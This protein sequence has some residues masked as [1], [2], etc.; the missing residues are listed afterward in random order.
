MAYTEW[1]DRLV[2]HFFG[3]HC[4]GQ[5]VRLM[6]TRRFLDE[7]MPDLGGTEGFLA[8]V[9]EGPEWF[10]AAGMPGRPRSLHETALA[11]YH[12]HL[13]THRPHDYPSV[14]YDAP[15][16]LAYLCLLCLAW[17]EGSEDVSAN[18]FYH[19]LD[20][21][22][23]EHDLT[24]QRLPQWRALW[25]GL[26]NWTV[27]SGGHLGVFTF[28]VLGHM[29]HVGTPRSQVLLNHENVDRLPR[30]FSHCGLQPA[31]GTTCEDLRQILYAHQIT[32]RQVL[33]H[34]LA[35]EIFEGGPLGRAAL[36]VVL[37]YLAEWDGVL[38]YLAEE[39]QN[40]DGG[41]P[42]HQQA[43]RNSYVLSV[44]L[45]CL[46]NGNGWLTTV[47]VLDQDD[48]SQMRVDEPPWRFASVTSQLL[49]ATTVGNGFVNVGVLG[50]ELAG[51]LDLVGSWHDDVGGRRQARLSLRDRRLRVFGWHN[52]RWLVEVDGLADE[53]CA[54][55][56]CASAMQPAWEACVQGCEPG[57]ILENELPQAG[58]PHGWR[59]ACIPDLAAVAAASRQE[60]RQLI[61]D[62]AQTP[63]IRLVGGSRVYAGVTRRTYLPYDP[64]KIVVSLPGQLQW[65]VQGAS[66]TEM[67][68]AAGG[69]GPVDGSPTY[70]TIDVDDDAHHVWARCMRDGQQVA[71]PV[72]I[73]ILRDAH[74]VASGGGTEFF[75]DR[76]GNR[77]TEGGLCGASLSEPPDGW[78]FDGED[79]VP[80]ARPA[81]EEPWQA[82]C[83]SFLESLHMA[84]RRL[85]F[86][87]VRR[88]AIDIAGVEAALVGREMRWLCG[89]GFVEIERDSRGRWA[90]VYPVP[91]CLY[92]LP[93]RRHGKYQ[94]VLSGC[95]RVADW[96]NAAQ[97]A[98]TLECQ[99][100]FHV[101]HTSLI[102]PRVSFF[103]DDVGHLQ[104][105]ANQSGARWLQFPP[106][107]AIAHWSA[108]LEEW[109]EELRWFEGEGPSPEREYAAPLFRTVNGNN[110]GIADCRLYCMED[111]QTHQHQ[112][113]TL[114]RQDGEAT[115]HTFVRDPAWGRWTVHTSAMRELMHLAHMEEEAVR[116]PYE[117]HTGS[118][119]LP[120]EL[121]LPD[122]LNRSL[123]LCSGLVPRVVRG[124]C[125]AYTFSGL[126]FTPGPEYRGLCWVY[127]QIP[128]RVAETV[129]SK[130]HARPVDVQPDV[131][132]AC[133][134]QA[135]R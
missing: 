5:P 122:V 22:Y 91:L 58:L 129:L 42:Q 93:L 21:L 50:D 121:T 59:L 72:S 75:L 95:A 1:L 31:E 126:H 57:Q 86:A 73:N 112:W 49:V 69:E 43:T 87:E 55:L 118:L 120:R 80:T 81:E 96:S 14:P 53:G 26:A 78:V 110:A 8:A 104:E 37:G 18:A 130:V 88:R 65:E 36:S 3:S 101:N 108:S 30:L 106:A 111:H 19:R 109:Q 10:G 63:P 60:I 35:Q 47:G 125:S 12:Q 113:F 33:G 39:A 2:S 25:N 99:V 98:R 24:A 9:R 29:V 61:G 124:D 135:I 32:T 16:Y 46:E 48:A 28:E 79:V 11:L 133:E 127:D 15:P 62:D 107:P 51:P 27:Q 102:P 94:A 116:V 4:E 90:Y 6:V 89:L 76:F 7:A 44:A 100:A 132:L 71:S 56:L 97:F 114:V 70:F 115:G 20:P 85:S 117:P 52:R 123:L 64:P 119:V 54:Y 74:V 68:A 13:A 40:A 66:I 41:G 23:P 83:F 34:V 77:D 105:V 134:C 92:L 45:R 67:P 131:D 38:P 84:N 82:P 103:H 128:R 17:T